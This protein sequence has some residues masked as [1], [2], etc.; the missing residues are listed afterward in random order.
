MLHKVAHQIKNEG[1][2]RTHVRTKCGLSVRRKDATTTTVKVN[3]YECL[4]FLLLKQDEKCKALRARI[5]EVLE[6]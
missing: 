4:T 6:L 5:L 2:Y 1:S 3:C